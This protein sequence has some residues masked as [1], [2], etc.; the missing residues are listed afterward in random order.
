[1]NKKVLL[2]QYVSFEL[3]LSAVFPY[4]DVFFYAVK[5]YKP[6]NMDESTTNSQ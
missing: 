6:C 1:M 5:Q 3:V 2:D 4:V